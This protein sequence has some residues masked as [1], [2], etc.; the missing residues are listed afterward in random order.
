VPEGS[1][2]NDKKM[3]E[4]QNVRIDRRTFLG[5]GI[6]TAASCLIPGETIASVNNLLEP[7]RRL[8]LLNLHTKEDINIA[9]WK[10]GKYIPDALNQLN[11]IFRDHYNG[12]VNQIDTDLFD[13]LFAIQQKIQSSEPFHLISGYRSKKTNERLRKHNRNAARKSLHIYGKAADIRLPDHKLKILRSAAYQLKGGGVGYYP[14]S[15]FVHVDVGRV[16]FWRE[17]V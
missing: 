8:C 16:R 6:I 2:D 5:L 1:C 7:E 10:N 3:I 17:D 4:A 14:K 11:Y 12:L 9:Y 13:F 15:N